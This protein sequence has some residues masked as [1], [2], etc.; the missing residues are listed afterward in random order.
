MNAHTYRQMLKGYPV[1]DEEW[2]R[3]CELTWARQEGCDQLELFAAAVILFCFGKLEYAWE[4]VKL[5]PS[6]GPDEP[7]KAYRR[8]ARVLSDLLPMPTDLDP[9]NPNHEWKIAD[10]LTVHGESLQWD[11]ERGLYDWPRIA[12]Q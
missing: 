10:W 4:I 8:L 2:L 3:D 9:L 5:L 1:S 6:Q 11:E 12:S 7:W